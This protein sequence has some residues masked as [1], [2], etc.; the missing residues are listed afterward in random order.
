[1]QAMIEF[2]PARVAR[3]L[4]AALLLLAHGTGVALAQARFTFSA[5]GSEVTDGLTSL[6]W[7]RCSE[8]QSFSSGTCVGEVTQLTHE[9]ALVH[10]R[11]QTGWRLPNIKELA[12][13]ADRTRVSPAIDIAAF[14][15]TPAVWY[16]SSSMNVSQGGAGVWRVGFPA[17]TVGTQPRDVSSAVRLVR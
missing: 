14:P 7:R 9:A 5:D 2:A 8:G 15:A 6:I 4:L 3:G 12:S 10:A 17:G 13:I 1:M 11:V 16:W